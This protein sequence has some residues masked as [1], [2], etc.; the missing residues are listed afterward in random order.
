MS[1]THMVGHH[2][3]PQSIRQSKVA[4]AADHE[5]NKGKHTSVADDP[6]TL[7][8][9]KQSSAQSKVA[10]NTADQSSYTPVADDAATTAASKSQAGASGAAYAKAAPAPEPVAAAEP[11]AAAP[12]AAAEPPAAAAAPPA[13][14]GGEKWVAEFDYDAAD[15]DEVSFKEGEIFI[16]VDIVDE[17][18]ARGTIESD[19]SRSGM[20]PSNY[21]VKQE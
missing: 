14:D 7:R 11:A 1:L 2:G 8:T 3:A 15:E 17:G 4:Y 13:A 21:I 18:W 5:K 12:P 10:Y 20:L 9:K 16:N 6:E 19:T